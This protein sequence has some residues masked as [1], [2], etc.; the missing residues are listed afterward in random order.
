MSRLARSTFLADEA[1]AL[2]VRRAPASPSPLASGLS[3]PAIALD[4]VYHV[5]TFDPSQK[6]QTHNSQSLEGNGLSVSQHPQ[7]WREIARLGDESTWKMEGKT[8]NQ[9]IDA[10]ALTA[11]H[12]AAI[13]T[14]SVERGLACATE[15]LRVSWFD[16]EDDE[17]RWMEFDASL[18]G[19]QA[20]ADAELAGYED[21]D[22]RL[23]RLPGWRST[24]ALDVRIGYAVPGT[25]VQDMVLTVFTE[26]VL[27]EKGAQ[28]VW[29]DD[30][31]DPAA[32]SAPRGVIHARALPSWTRRRVEG[33]GEGEGENPDAEATRPRARG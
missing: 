7:A 8:L 6:G 28:G 2:A 32:L 14:W 24:P 30:R 27:F 18:P 5:G 20:N 26:D 25:L 19:A 9:F 1:E 31:L 3:W 15:V 13:M 23:E 29:W 22:P 16:E 4:V 21:N 10:R 17:R 12:W 11:A 33:D